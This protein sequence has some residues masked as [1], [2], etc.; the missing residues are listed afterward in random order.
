M[1]NFEL[2]DR[3]TK[4]AGRCIK[5]CQALPLKKMGS[6]NLADQLFRSSTSTAANYAEASHAESRKD[7]VHKLKIVLKELNEARTWLKIISEAEYVPSSSLTALITESD[8]LTRILSSSV[9][10]AKKGL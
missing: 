10:T 7:F 4:F 5:V 2:E 6:A 9:I 3:I 1:R 8:E